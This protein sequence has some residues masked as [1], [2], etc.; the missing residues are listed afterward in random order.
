MNTKDF[1]D[2]LKLRRSK[3]DISKESALSKAELEV[4]L[5]DIME[6]MPSPFD[7][8]S[9]RAVLLFDSANQKF[10]NIVLESLRRRSKNPEKF[11]ATEKKIADFAAGF[12][13]VLFFDDT[14]VVEASAKQFPSYAE[15]F[16]IWAQH[17]NGMLQFAMWTSLANSGLGASLQHYNPIIDDEVK[18]AFSLPQSWSLI[19]QM[20]FGKS[21]SVPEAKDPS[22]AERWKI[23]KD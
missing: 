13:T 10:W 5:K 19:A 16:K 17:A 23:F 3:Y 12:G 22:A 1:L 7:N 20:P 14:A 11:H 2:A 6:L 18:S 4:M 9:A 21:L 8:R 15:N